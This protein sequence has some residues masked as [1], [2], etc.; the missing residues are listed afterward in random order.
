MAQ[1]EQ[2]QMAAEFIR[3]ME[4]RVAIARRSRVAWALVVTDMDEAEPL[5]VSVFA[6]TVVTASLLT[7]TARLL[8]GQQT[9]HLRPAPEPS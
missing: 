6:D 5:V 1:E 3:F 7:Q 2:R 4:E 9:V 8:T